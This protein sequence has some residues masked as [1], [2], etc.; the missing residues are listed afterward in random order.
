MKFVFAALL[1]LVTALG[2]TYHRCRAPVRFYI[3]DEVHAA[4]F[5]FHVSGYTP[6]NIA[7]DFG[8]QPINPARVDRIVDEVEACAAKLAPGG[9]LPPEVVLQGAC[10]E[11]RVTLPFPR[12]CMAIKVI[13]NSFVSETQFA[14]SKHQMIPG[15]VSMDCTEKGMPSGPCYRRSGIINSDTI[16]TTP[17]MYLL[18]DSLVKL[19][20]HCETPW[21]S[22]ALTKCMTPTTL[23]LDDGSGP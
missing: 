12:S 13:T 4:D 6:K 1:L 19:Y 7:V 16:V 15:W 20:M 21:S 14:G 18:K 5:P 11:A 23:P 9:I 22:P 8:G 17:S 3:Q 2:C 10:R